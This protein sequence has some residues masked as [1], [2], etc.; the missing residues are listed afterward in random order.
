MGDEKGTLKTEL[1]EW[2]EWDVA[3]QKLGVHLGL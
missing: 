2:T 3:G 1:A